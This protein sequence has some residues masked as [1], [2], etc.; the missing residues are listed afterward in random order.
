MKTKPLWK[1]ARHLRRYANKTRAILI[2]RFPAAIVPHGAPKLPLKIGI[3]DD[4]AAAMP[5]MMRGH[6]AL[7]LKDYTLGP[8]YFLAVVTGTH[9]VD[10]DGQPAGEISAEHRAYAAAML[11]KWEACGFRRDSALRP[12]EMARVA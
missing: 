6:I 4:I 2:E 5:E 3:A 10:L 9:R 11:A 7:F 12:D 8:T 1:P